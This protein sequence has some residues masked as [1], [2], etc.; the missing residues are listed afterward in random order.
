MK[1]LKR[2][3]LLFRHLARADCGIEKPWNITFKINP[4]RVV[5][6]KMTPDKIYS[7]MTLIKGIRPGGY[8]LPRRA[9]H[10]YLVFYVFIFLYRMLFGVRPKTAGFF[11]LRCKISDNI[12]FLWFLRLPNWT[13][14]K[15]LR[16]GFGLGCWSTTEANGGCS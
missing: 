12:F 4:I 15:R 7:K 11:S 10:N 5:Y 8:C 1:L 6:S 14:P 3:P 16:L 9:S 13:Y 2:Y